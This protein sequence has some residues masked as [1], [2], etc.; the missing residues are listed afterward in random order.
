MRGFIWSLPDRGWVV[1]LISD[2]PNRVRE[3]ITDYFQKIAS[4][5]P[6]RFYARPQAHK[7]LVDLFRSLS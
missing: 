3:K 1:G 7:A 5:Q 4:S 2:Y 6:Y